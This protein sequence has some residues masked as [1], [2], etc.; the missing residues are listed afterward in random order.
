MSVAVAVAV[1]RVRILMYMKLDWKVMVLAINLNGEKQKLCTWSIQREW[2]I[3][4]FRFNG[5][6]F[7]WKRGL[8]IYLIQWNRTKW[9]IL[10]FLFVAHINRIK[11]KHFW[12]LDLFR[13]LGNCYYQAIEKKVLGNVK[14][15][16]CKYVGTSFIHR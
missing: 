12:L 5:I 3:L 16:N 7:D 15:E 14:C 6:K 13:Y 10:V 2:E 8:K 4:Y 1:A 11:L 9:N